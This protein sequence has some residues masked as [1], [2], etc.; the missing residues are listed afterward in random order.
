MQQGRRYLRHNVGGASLKKMNEYSFSA[1]SATAWQNL[2]QVRLKWQLVGGWAANLQGSLWG[3][4]RAF[5]DVN[6]MGTELQ[7]RRKE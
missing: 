6:L 5:V 2:A 4:Y 7:T 1:D 3:L